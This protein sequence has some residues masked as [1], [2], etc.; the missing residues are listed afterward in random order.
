[1]TDSLSAGAI[2]AAGYTVAR[3][4]ARALIAGADMVLYNA[5]E[6]R[7]GSV[8]RNIVKAI[9]RSVRNG[10]LPRQRLRK[11]VLHVLHIKRVSLCAH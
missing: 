2:S 9:T 6:D 5:V 3:A 7:A 11:A 1:M 4:S 10:S 8:L